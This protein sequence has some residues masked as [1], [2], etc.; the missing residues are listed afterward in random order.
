M[1][2]NSG[3]AG[4]PTLDWGAIDLVVFDV[5]G[6]LYSQSRLRLVMLG[7]LIADAWACRSISTI[8]A[9]RVFRQVRE[10]LGD[11]PGIDFLTQQYQQAA[12]RCQL[13]TDELRKLTT[14]WLEQRPLRFLAAC[15][16]SRLQAVFSALHASGKQVAVF[17]DYPAVEKLFALGL[18]ASPIVCATDAEVARLKPDPAGLLLVLKQCGVPPN[19]TL[20]IGDRFDRDAL[21]AKRAGVRA[22]IRSRKPH[23]EFQTFQKFDDAVFVPLLRGD[24]FEGRGLGQV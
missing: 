6:T 4:S 16:Y 8:N 13:S 5:D 3:Q 21:A 12:E 2:L 24:R 7:Q 10:S 1:K 22:L 15:R 14:D 23:P 11:Q 20:M 9:L 17:S 18:Q 19:R